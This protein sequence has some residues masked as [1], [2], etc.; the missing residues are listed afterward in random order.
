M[1]LYPV[2]FEK[3]LTNERRLNIN[4]NAEIRNPPNPALIMS[5]Y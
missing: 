1:C 2:Q 5:H 3:T 4:I